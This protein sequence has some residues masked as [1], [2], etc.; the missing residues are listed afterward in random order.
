MYSIKIFVFYEILHNISQ[1]LIKRTFHMFIFNS[2][3]LCFTQ[4]DR[5]ST[6]HQSRLSSALRADKPFF[7]F[8]INSRCRTSR[9]KN[10]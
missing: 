5:N 8:E 1:N 10:I 3:R 9:P 7:Y 4:F 2:I 6:Q